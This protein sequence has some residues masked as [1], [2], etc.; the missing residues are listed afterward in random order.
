VCP[1]DC[2]FENPDFRETKEELLEKYKQ[3]H[4]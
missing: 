2:I 4:G 3:L 1:S